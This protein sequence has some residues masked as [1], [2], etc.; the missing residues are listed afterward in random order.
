MPCVRRRPP[1]RPSR[2]DGCADRLTSLLGCAGTEGPVRLSG[3]AASQLGV[4]KGRLCRRAALFFEA[5]GRG[6]GTIDARQDAPDPLVERFRPGQQSQNQVRLLREV[7]EIAG[8][9]ED[10]VLA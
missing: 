4:G 6:S 10:A 7:E 3:F 1:Y 9:D 8:M 2:K 5:P